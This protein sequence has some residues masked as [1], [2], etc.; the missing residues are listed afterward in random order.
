MSHVLCV[1]NKTF[2]RAIA[3]HDHVM[4][5]TAQLARN[6]GLKVRVNHKVDT[7]AADNKKQ[8][9]VQA[10]DFDS[11]GYEHLVWD[12]SLVSDRIGSSLRHGL[13]SGSHQD[14]QIQT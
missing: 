7:T 13:N 1:V 8:G 10:M 4:N 2:I 11:P 6:S 9:D 5:V 14:C 3:G 12:V